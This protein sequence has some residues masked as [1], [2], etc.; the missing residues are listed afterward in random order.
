MDGFHYYLRYIKFGLGRC[1]EE[2]SHEIRDGHITREEGISLMEK[3]EG[4]FPKKYYKDFKEYLD[5]NDDKFWEIIDSWR[6]DN[7]WKK[8]NNEWKLKYPI[9]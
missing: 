8:E 5:I 1:C 2:A 9:K 7:L 6:S 4:E 3:Y